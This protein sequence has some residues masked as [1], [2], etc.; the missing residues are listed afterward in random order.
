LA[1]AI[2][3]I[4]PTGTLQNLGQGPSEEKTQP[5][6]E[7]TTTEGGSAVNKSY[8]TSHSPAQP[9]PPK[10]E[11]KDP[12]EITGAAS[13]H[14]ALNETKADE[15]RADKASPGTTSTCHDKCEP[16]TDAELDSQPAE[17]IAEEPSVPNEAK[18][19]HVEKEPLVSIKQEPTSPSVWKSAASPKRDPGSSSSGDEARAPLRTESV[20][21]QTCN[22]KEWKEEPEWKRKSDGSSDQEVGSEICPGGDETE[23]FVWPSGRGTGAD[24]CNREKAQSKDIPPTT[25]QKDKGVHCRGYMGCFGTFFPPSS[26]V[27]Q[28]N[29]NHT[30]M[31]QFI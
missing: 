26:P 18:P 3:F 27:M 2:S 19:V 30:V 11:P 23:A 15:E 8:N 29:P 21:T 10:I 5:R 9:T 1:K 28:L 12:I 22:T 16:D 25:A 7:K 14:R 24:H 20:Q 6:S 31:K 17:K 4:V 13:G